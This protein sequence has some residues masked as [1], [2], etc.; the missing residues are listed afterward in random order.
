MQKEHDVASLDDFF[1][2][3]ASPSGDASICG[4]TLRRCPPGMQAEL[5]TSNL[6]MAHS[7]VS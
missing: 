2:L 3:P 6:G 4:L 7:S 5:R 1:F